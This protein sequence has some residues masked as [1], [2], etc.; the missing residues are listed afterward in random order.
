MNFL[1]RKSS[2]IRK[3]VEKS[4]SAFEKANQYGE[5]AKDLNYSD[6][7]RKTFLKQE[8]KYIEKGNIFHDKAKG[9]L[10]NEYSKLAGSELTVELIKRADKKVSE[11]TGKKIN[12][13]NISSG[14]VE[15][16]GIK[17]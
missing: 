16:E 12:N 2:A 10:A 8:K 3:N 6:K 14:A 15:F 1:K 13:A 7:K 11:Y 9:I 17:D 5:K 4:K